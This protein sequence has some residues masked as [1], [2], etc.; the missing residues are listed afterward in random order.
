MENK[1]KAALE[2]ALYNVMQEVPFSV[3]EEYT[4]E[5]AL[6]MDSGSVPFWKMLYKVEARTLAKL[7]KKEEV[8]EVWKNVC[9][10]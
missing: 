5:D 2:E 7:L 4:L 10:F 8:E 3:R 1:I 6:N 9:T